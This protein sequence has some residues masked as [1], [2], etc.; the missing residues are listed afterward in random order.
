MFCTN[1]TE[2]NG[3]V[4][5]TTVLLELFRGENAIV[6]VIGLDFEAEGFCFVLNKLFAT[7]GLSSVKVLLEYTEQ[8][9]ACMVN[10]HGPASVTVSIRSSTIGVETPTANR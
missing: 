6:R 10:I 7:D 8:F 4:L 9:R 1:T 2:R 5:E 3:L